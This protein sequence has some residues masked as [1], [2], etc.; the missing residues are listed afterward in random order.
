LV[1][2]KE[3][4]NSVKLFCASTVSIKRSAMRRKFFFALCILSVFLFSSCSFFNHHAA[5]IYNTAIKKAPFDVVIIPG[6]PYDSAGRNPLFKARM[7]W[8]KELYNTGVV[9]NIIFSGAAVH[10]PYVEAMVMKIMADSMGIPTRHTF[11]ED[12]ALH[13]N[14][15]VFY[16]VKLASSMCFKNIAVATD[17]IQTFIIKK[18][19][20]KKYQQISFLPFNFTAMPG[21]Y[22]GS[23]PKINASDAFVENFVPLKQREQQ[24]TIVE[25]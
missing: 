19:T 12:K 10:S 1:S 13:S 25:D 24:T 2:I 22:K 5:V 7:L 4:I 20:Q 6:L 11:I 16:G 21:F 23:I 3:P 8:A 18:I 17:P 15:N 14:E 9:K